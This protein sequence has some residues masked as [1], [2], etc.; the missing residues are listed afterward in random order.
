M[1]YTWNSSLET[2]NVNIDIQHKKLVEALNKLLEACSKGQGRSE[3]KKVTEFLY[4]YTTTHFA[5]EEKLQKEIGYPDYINHKKYH[6]DF[7]KVVA[8]IMDELERDG[9]NI[10]LIGKINSKI[11]DWLVSHIKREDFKI[12]EY[13]RQKNNK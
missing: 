13:I 5:D 11:G 1:A 10:V 12:A 9:P 4:E 2:G 3:L 7:K 6:A 8:E